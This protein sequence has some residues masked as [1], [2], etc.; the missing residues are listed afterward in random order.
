MAA[1]RARSAALG[2]VDAS[3][4][5]VVPS[6]APRETTVDSTVPDQA[7]EARGPDA[8][9][10]GND[11]AVTPTPDSGPD[12]VPDVTP[13]RAPDVTSTPDA[14]DGGLRGDGP[15]PTLKGEE[16]AQAVEAAMAAQRS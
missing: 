14:N 12:A 8:G 7:A 13:D 15:P 3:P 11:G 4:D 5:V 16:L 9:P 6:D 1:A 10:D 2:G